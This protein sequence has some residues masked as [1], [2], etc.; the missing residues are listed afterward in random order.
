MK[1]ITPELRP[2]VLGQLLLMQAIISS[3]PDKTSIFDFTCR[4][5]ANLPGVEQVNYSINKEEAIAT[6]IVRFPVQTRS[7]NYGELLIDVSDTVAFM[8]YVEYLKNFCF[9]IGVILD[10]RAKKHI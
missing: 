3:L 9:I 8:P 5:L 10:E 2:E 4:G 1:N 6:S 7:G